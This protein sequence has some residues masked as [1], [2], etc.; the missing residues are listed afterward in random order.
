MKS[1]FTR[2]V[3]A[4]AASALFGGLMLSGQD[5]K[6]VANIPFAFEASHVNLPAGEYRVTETNSN[7][8]FRLSDSEGHSAFV[9]MAPLDT[10]EPSKPSLT[11]VCYGSQ[12]ILSQVR[13]DSGSSYGVSK[14]SIEKD[15][16]RRLGITTL[17]SVALTHR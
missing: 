3:L 12:R 17:V 11:F 1:Q 15:I 9:S 14:S 13:T 16:N 2:I 4:T 10:S 6:S 5:Q 7:G 8:M